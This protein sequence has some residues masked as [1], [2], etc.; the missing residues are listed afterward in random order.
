ML[1]S[2]VV[3]EEALA[4][5]VGVMDA[6]AAGFDTLLVNHEL[7]GDVQVE[8]IV[9]DIV[10][11][12]REEQQRQ[13][14]Q[15]SKFP[16]ATSGPFYESPSGEKSK[17]KTDRGF[18]DGD[19]HMNDGNIKRGLPARRPRSGIKPCYPSPIPV[20]PRFRTLWT[21]NPFHMLGVA[22]ALG[23]AL[24]CAILGAN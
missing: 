24:L 11:L 22:G 9:K 18:W 17:G 2:S 15:L 19:H 20:R 3:V 13:P 23:A 14:Q 1:F 7:V 8:S 10:Q 4:I 5:R 21:L 6:I 12:C 16:V